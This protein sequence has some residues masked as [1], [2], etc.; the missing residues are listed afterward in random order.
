MTN[1]S[2]KKKRRSILSV[3]DREVQILWVVGIVCKCIPMHESCTLQVLIEE[4]SKTGF[5]EN[6]P[7]FIL[8]FSPTIMMVSCRVD[9]FATGC[10]DSSLSAMLN[11]GNGFRCKAQHRIGPWHGTWWEAGFD[12]LQ[13]FDRLSDAQAGIVAGCPMAMLLQVLLAWSMF[14]WIPWQARELFPP[15]RTGNHQLVLISMQGLVATATKGYAALR[16]TKFKMIR[17]NAGKGNELV[18][19]RLRN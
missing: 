14:P 17:H 9:A 13:D 7:A 1:G 6:T 15:G 5:G 11:G 2:E 8:M 16:S 19:I 18:S 4:L 3:F 12:E 10:Y